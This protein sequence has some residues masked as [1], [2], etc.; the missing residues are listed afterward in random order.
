MKRTWWTT[1][2][3][4]SCLSLEVVSSIPAGSTIIYRLLCGFI[5][6]SLCQ[7]KLNQQIRICICMC[8]CIC[9]CMHKGPIFVIVPAHYI[10]VPSTE[11]AV[12]QN[13][14]WYL[15]VFWIPKPDWQIKLRQLETMSFSRSFLSHVCGLVFTFMASWHLTNLGRPFYRQHFQGHFPDRKMILFWF[16]F[17]WSF[18][19]NDLIDS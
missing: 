15:A 7:T 16:K 9:I 12:F 10:T 6:V 18:I 17:H 5:C 2:S 1:G 13:D 4:R 3:W 8:I 14:R 19:L 11:S